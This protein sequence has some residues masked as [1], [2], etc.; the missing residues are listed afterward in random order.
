M[1]R[2]QVTEFLGQVPLLQCLPGSSIRRIAEAVQ[3]K[4]YEPGDYVAREGEPV[5]GLCIILDGQVLVML[6]LASLI[7]RDTFL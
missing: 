4:H 6:V 1:D 3:V 5:D 7:Y 2:E